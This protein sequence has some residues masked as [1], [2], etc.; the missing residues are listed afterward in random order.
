MLKQL[1]GIDDMPTV[2]RYFTYYEVKDSCKASSRIALAVKQKY[3]G[4]HSIKGTDKEDTLTEFLAL[5]RNPRIFK[6]GA[7]NAFSD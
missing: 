6:G 4:H 7:S 3:E 1:T 5:K 2:L